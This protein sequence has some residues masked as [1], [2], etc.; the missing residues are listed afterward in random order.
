MSKI[1]LPWLDPHNENAPFPSPKQALDN[2]RGLV[3]AGGDLSPARILRAYRL[4]LFPWYEQGQPIL[5]WSPNPRGVLYPNA[6]IA[7]KSLQK[8]LKRRCWQITY[9]E[10]F[11]DVIA[12]CAQPRDYARSTWITQDMMRAY[13]HLHQ[14]N[15]AHS[16][17]VCDQSGDLIG[18]IYGLSIG[19]IFFA[20]SMFSRVTDTSKVALLYLC[21]YLDNWGYTLIDTQLPSSHLTSL[22]GIEISR[23]DY[24]SRLSKHIEAAPH[25]HAWQ[26]GHSID[27][28]HWLC[29]I[30]PKT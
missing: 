7:H 21:A 2:P 17:E 8:T 3:A 1:N 30:K 15:H 27:I 26:K 12:A 19:T 9:D 25:Y 13:C 5:W 14:L 29:Q 16:V 6:F 22:G 18:G 11:Q 28:H 4:G 23:K 24:L 10:S 20:E